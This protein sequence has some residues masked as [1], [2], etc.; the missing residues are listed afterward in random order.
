MYLKDS[1]D[2]GYSPASGCYEHCN[3]PYGSIKG[4]EFPEPLSKTSDSPDALHSTKLPTKLAYYAT[5]WPLCFITAPT[6]TLYLQQPRHH[7]APCLGQTAVVRS[8]NS[9]RSRMSKGLRVTVCQLPAS[10]SWCRWLVQI[11]LCSLLFTGTSETR[12]WC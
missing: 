5:L 10:S 11:P 8:C 4:V 9:T 7:G 12:I 1:T 2:L 3:E 6:L